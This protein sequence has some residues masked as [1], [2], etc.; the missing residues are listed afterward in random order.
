MAPS[1]QVSKDVIK[2]LKSRKLYA[3]ESYEEVIMDLLYDSK[4][5][6]KETKVGLAKACREYTEG[7]IKPMTL[8]GLDVL[9]GL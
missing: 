9:L 1:I 8:K 6:S 2:E 7:K 5:L 3:C 4:E